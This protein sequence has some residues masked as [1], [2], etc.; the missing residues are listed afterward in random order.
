MKRYWIRVGT[1]ALLAIVLVWEFLPGIKA[2]PQTAAP[3]LEPID[4]EGQPLASNV[5]R[6]IQA[7]EVL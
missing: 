7:L 2:V 3:N 5:A 1:T 4:V 6:V